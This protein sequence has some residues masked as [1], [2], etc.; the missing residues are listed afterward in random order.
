[1]ERENSHNGKQQFV[2]TEVGN[3]VR[4]EPAVFVANPNRK[5]GHILV[6]YYKTSGNTGHHV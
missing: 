4:G 5:N 2:A 6:T 1:M 3:G